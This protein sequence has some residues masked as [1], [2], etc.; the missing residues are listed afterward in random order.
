MDYITTLRVGDWTIEED[1]QNQRKRYQAWPEINY[2]GLV[3]THQL[4]ILYI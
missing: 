1:K 4:H 3:I 2:F